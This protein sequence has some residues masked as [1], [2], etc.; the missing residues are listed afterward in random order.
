MKKRTHQADQYSRRECLEIAGIP[1]EVNNR[2][3]EKFIFDEIFRKLDLNI[4]ACDVSACHRLKNSSRV[5]M[6]LVNQKVAEAIVAN[7]F[8]L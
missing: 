5:I 8:K 3:L 4:N 7:K 6:K 1:S 2:C